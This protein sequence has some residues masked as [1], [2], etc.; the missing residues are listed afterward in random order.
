MISNIEIVKAQARN[1]NMPTSSFD[2]SFVVSDE[3]A[4]LQLKSDIKNPKKVIVK[5]RNFESDRI[6]GIQLIKNTLGSKS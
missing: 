1:K 5:K 3:K 6:S 4:I 2:K